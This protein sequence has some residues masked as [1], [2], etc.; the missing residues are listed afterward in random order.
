VYLDA[1]VPENGQS[2]VSLTA[3]RAT[4]RSGQRVYL[5]ALACRCVRRPPG[6]CGDRRCTNHAA[7]DR[8]F[9][10][11]D[12]ALRQHRSRQKENLHLRERSGADHLHALLEKLKNNKEWTVHTLPCT[13]I[14]QMDLP[15]EL[16]ALL[17]QAIP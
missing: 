3:G 2:L 15:D 14:V 12:K 16:T 8:V 9:H 13:H 17:L 11:G 5:G 10:S 7:P 4:P 6:S 1:F